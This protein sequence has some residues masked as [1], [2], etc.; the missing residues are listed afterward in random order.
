MPLRVYHPDDVD[1]IATARHPGLSPFVVPA[2]AG[3]PGNGNGHLAQ[4]STKTVLARTDNVPPTGEE[5]LR[6]VFAAAL[7]TLTSDSSDSSESSQSR[8]FLTLDE[9]AAVSGLSR[10]YL[11]RA[12]AAERL[13]AIRDG[14]R[15][16][17][18]R[19]D[20]EAL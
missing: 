19:T 17:I 13:P 18:R 3:M 6:L 20:L 5:I 7:R 1:R 8:L 4:P 2:G 15:W 16:R 14:R 11:R 10:T 9:A 12:I